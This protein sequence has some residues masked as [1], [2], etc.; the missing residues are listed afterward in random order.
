MG[1]LSMRVK[2]DLLQIR[3]IYVFSRSRIGLTCADDQIHK[4]THAHT[5]SFAYMRY[6]GLE[7]CPRQSL[8]Y[9]EL[10][11]EIRA[12]R[13]ADKSKTTNSI[14]EHTFYVKRCVS[15]HI[16]HFFPLDIWGSEQCSHSCDES[17]NAQ[18]VSSHEPPILRHSAASELVRISEFCGYL[19]SDIRSTAVKWCA[20]NWC[21]WALGTWASSAS[22][23]RTRKCKTEKHALTMQRNWFAGDDLFAKSVFI[24]E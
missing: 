2:I 15:W 17:D 6:S 23:F 18:S 19:I 11:I 13:P 20:F 5:C 7:S 16:F 22:E 9:A 4:R 14:C 12:N 10:T 8:L 21:S 1:F 24:F 3:F